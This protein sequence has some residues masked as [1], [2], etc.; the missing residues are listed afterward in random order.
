MGK[1][2]YLYVTK[3]YKGK[4]TDPKYF[5]DRLLKDPRKAARATID[6]IRPIGWGLVGL[7]LIGALGHLVFWRTKRVEEKKEAESEGGE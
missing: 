6:V 1:T 4:L 7:T 5:G 3:K 2:H